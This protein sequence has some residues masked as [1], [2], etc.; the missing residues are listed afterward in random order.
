MTDRPSRRTVAAWASSRPA[1]PAADVRLPTCLPGRIGKQ[2]QVFGQQDQ[3]D[4]PGTR[5]RG[6]A[7]ERGTLSLG[8]DPTMKASALFGAGWEDESVEVLWKD[9]ERAFCRLWHD[10][11]QGGG[12]HAFIPLPL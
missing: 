7:G 3:R 6:V 8:G 5:V 11:A 9:S 4:R 1:S 10:G 12:R 2:I